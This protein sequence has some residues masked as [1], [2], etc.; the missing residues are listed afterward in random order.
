MAFEE[1]LTGQLD[2]RHGRPQRSARYET[3]TGFSSIVDPL[4]SYLGLELRQRRPGAVVRTTPAGQRCCTSA[5]N[6]NIADPLML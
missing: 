6:D 2:L 3:V 4:A 1:M 5:P